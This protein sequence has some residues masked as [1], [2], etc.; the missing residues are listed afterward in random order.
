MNALNATGFS[1]TPETAPE[2]A[3]LTA[4][5]RDMIPFFKPSKIMAP[6]S[7]NLAGRS[8]PNHDS[9]FAKAE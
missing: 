4:A 1:I 8:T 5:T 9:T 2:M 7:V 3:S 6:K